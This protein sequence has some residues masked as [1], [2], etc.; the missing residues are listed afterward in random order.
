MPEQQNILFIQTDQ[1]RLDALG[2]Y[3]NPVVQTPNIDALAEDGIR[4]NSAFTCTGV[5]TPSRGALLS[6]CYPHKTGMIYN[7]E[8]PGGMGKR[9]CEYDT[10]ITPFSRPLA[11]RGYECLHVG[12][13]HIGS[14][15]DSKPEHY[16]FKGVFYPGY[17]FPREHPHY[18]RHLR[19]FGEDGFNLARPRGGA[20]AARYF[21]E[22]N[23]PPEATVPGYLATQTIA[24][25]KRVKRSG[26]LFFLGLNFWGPHIPV[27]IPRE[28]LTMYDPDK[29]PIPESRQHITDNRPEIVAIA[30]RLWGG[31]DLTETMVRRITA[32]YYG[33][34]TLID[35]QVGRVVAELGRLGLAENTTIVFTTDHGS[36][37]GAHG[38]QDKGLNM[39]DEVYRIPM[40]IS[41]PRVRRKGLPVDQFV[42]N[43]D[44]TPTFVELAGGRVPE[45]Y[46]GSS[47]VPY[48]DGNLRHSIRRDVVLEAF[49]H[50]VPFPQR[51]VRDRRYKYIC[52]AADKDEFYDIANDPHELC[53]LVDMIDSRTLTRYR[54]RL[55]R[56]MQEHGDPLCRIYARSKLMTD[57]ARSPLRTAR[58]EGKRRV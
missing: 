52:N 33:Y 55:Y 15:F 16:G 54:R 14:W 44:L 24:A 12:K 2:C 10:D 3:G 7:P 40:I 36:T 58:D 19:R 28:Y 29:V 46:D 51:T 56:W 11:K 49:G 26:N 9:L 39:Y 41:G 13:W 20:I 43:L 17:G 25:L 38:L 37:L 50:Q 23:V 42:M 45:E 22:H 48:I 30:H 47:L 35:E 6:G 1:H 31:S 8:L 34:V 57:Y 5:C 32:A 53:N 4:F 21:M 18:M 27:Y